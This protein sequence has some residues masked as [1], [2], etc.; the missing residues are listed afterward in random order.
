ME[1]QN[2]TLEKMFRAYKWARNNSLQMLELAEEN[3]ILDH[4]P[5]DNE[6]S[7]Q[8]I[9]HQFQCLTSTTDT[10]YRQLSG[11]DNQ[12]FGVLVK[13]G[14]EIPKADI[15]KEALPEILKTQLVDLE[16]LL[17]NFSNDDFEE[18]VKAIQAICNHEY[19]HQGQLLVLVRQAGV[20]VPERFKAA[21]VL[22][23][24]FFC[25]Y[26]VVIKAPDDTTTNLNESTP[27]KNVLSFAPE[28][29]SFILDKKK[30]ATYRLGRKYDYL[31]AGD[32]VQL[33][34]SRTG[35]IVGEAIIASK[36]YTL[37]GD[38]PLEGRGHESYKDKEHQRKVFSG[39]YAY[40]GRPISDDDEFLVL[41]FNQKLEPT[42]Q[43]GRQRLRCS[44]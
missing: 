10:Y 40:I 36:S 27:E 14:T 25:Y 35:E 15:I 44:R 5:E 19:L 21:F 6:F 32:K 12:D 22:Q 3:N 34:N 29:I 23:Q 42:N 2:K 28:L 43:I 1:F 31:N 30:T 4:K 9:L 41:G 38:L 33:Q 24:S 39:Y 17:K 26:L 7:F 13:H 11:A 20:D 37:F 18:N 8:P 16:R